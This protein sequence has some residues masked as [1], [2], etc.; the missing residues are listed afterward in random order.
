MFPHILIPLLVFLVVLTIFI[1]ITPNGEIRRNLR[2]CRIGDVR[3][4]KRQER[5]Q[6]KEMRLKS[7]E[8]EHMEELQAQVVIRSP[9]EPPSVHTPRVPSNYIPPNRP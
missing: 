5:R 8:I 6:A 2:Q 7:L 3:R 9:W 1:L 4:L